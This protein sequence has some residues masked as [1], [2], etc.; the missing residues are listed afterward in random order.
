MS[1]GLKTHSAREDRVM[2]VEAFLS[3][4]HTYEGYVAHHRD[5]TAMEAMVPAGASVE[6]DDAI[7]EATDHP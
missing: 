1:E 3:A 6:E 2:S 4:S 7:L 5:I